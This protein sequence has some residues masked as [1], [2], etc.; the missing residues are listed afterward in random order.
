MAALGKSSYLLLV[1]LLSLLLLSTPVESKKKAPGGGMGGAGG[2]KF[3]L[4]LSFLAFG[5][6]KMQMVFI[7]IREGYIDPLGIDKMS[8]DF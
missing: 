1:I 5:N 7:T 8:K 4:N 2:R 6:K 3:T